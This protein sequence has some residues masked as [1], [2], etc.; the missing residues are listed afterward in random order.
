MDELPRTKIIATLGP[1]TQHAEVLRRLLEAGAGIVRLNFAHGT[2]EEHARLLETARGAAQTVGVPVAVLADLPG[3]KLRIGDLPGGSVTLAAGQPVVLVTNGAAGAGE[4]PVAYR[5]LAHDVRPGDHV[6]LQDGELDLEVRTVAPSRVACAVVCG[7]TLRAHAG[8]N[9]PGV[10]LSVRALTDEDSRRLHWAI[11]HDVDYIGLSFVE[12]P[13]EIARVRRLIGEARGAARVIAKI[14]RRRALD[15]IEEIAASADGVMVARGD[16]A[17]ET[18]IED[19]PVVQKRIIALCNRLGVPVITATQMLESMIEH[20]RPTRA[21]AADVANAVFDGTDALMLSGETAIGA[22]PIEAVATMAAIAR[23]A[24]G[25]LPYNFLLRERRRDRE[26]E[27]GEAIAL[28]ACEAAEVIGAAAI[29]AATDSG[30]TARRVTRFRPR[31]PIVAVTHKPSTWRQ[32]VLVWGVRPALVEPVPDL[33]TLVARGVRAAVELG[34][35]RPGEQVVVTA[36]LPLGRSGSTNFLKVVQ[37]E[38]A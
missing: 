4:I 6:Y 15:C 29:I 14:E 23:R 25:A 16:L 37:V 17:V 30:S 24:E 28:A 18:S 20:S 12:D 32:L 33:D 1:A 8:L 26:M 10:R 27:T 3:P 9:V 11:A 35:A 36:G 5:G 21:E 19:V 22:Y 7:G 34:V 38:G 31:R 2:P 13:A